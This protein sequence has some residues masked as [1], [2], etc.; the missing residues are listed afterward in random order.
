VSI[1]R[2]GA[3]GT[4]DDTAPF[5]PQTS[6]LQAIQV[7]D[8]LIIF[9]AWH[10]DTAGT[11]VLTDVVGN[12][13]E[14]VARREYSG[15]VLEGYFTINRTAAA[16]TGNTATAAITQTTCD[17]SCIAYWIYRGVARQGTLVAV[18]GVDTVSNATALSGPVT[19]R[20]ECALI[21]ALAWQ[22]SSGAILGQS[23]GFANYRDELNVNI[24]LGTMGKIASGGTYEAGQTR[25]TPH[26]TTGMLIALQ[27]QP[28]SP[29]PVTKR[30]GSRMVSW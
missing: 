4:T 16:S 21:A 3:L 14:R 27:M 11:C 19:V 15:M 5:N 30:R 28:G 2:I 12:V 1:V 10:G 9:V 7:G 24:G 23:G 26:D 18:G 6:N 20:P 8:A 22:P 29:V 25:S 17:G 13:Y